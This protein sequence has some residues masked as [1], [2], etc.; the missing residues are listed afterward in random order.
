MELSSERYSVFL[1]TCPGLG[2]TE[3]GVQLE[4]RG[5]TLPRLS[6]TSLLAS[7]HVFV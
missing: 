2:T 4:S 1:R 5:H 6:Q 7:D 3:E